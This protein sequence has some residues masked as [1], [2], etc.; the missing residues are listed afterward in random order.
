MKKIIFIVGPTAVG[1]SDVAMELAVKL[2][3]EIVCC[4][5]M[6]IYREINIASNKPSQKDLEKVPHHLVNVISIKR[7]FDVMQYNKM[8][9]K[10]IK[11]IHS[12]EK[13]PLI[14][15]G[16][17]MYV[18]I[19]L[20]GIF[21]GAP[22]NIELRTKLMQIAKK[23]GNDFLHA[24]LS[25]ID[26][27]AAGRIHKND[28]KRVIRAMEVYTMTNE[29]ISKLQEKRDGIW[30]KYD[31]NIFVINRDRD[32]LYGRINRRVE[33]MFKQGLIEEAQKAKK[34]L[35][36]RKYKDGISTAESIIGMKEVFEYLDGK[37]D[38][39]EAKAQIK[40]NTRRL[41]KRQ[42]TWFIKDQRFKWIIVDPN[43]GSKD[44]VKKIISILKEGSSNHGK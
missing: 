26:P 29:Q 27:I 6:Q 4:D 40:Q 10:A 24:K 14:V 28:V 42:I 1:K 38:L 9:L 44:A 18:Q 2:K 7:N 12:R 43:Q 34:I 13:I 36:S 20:D 39:D 22:M 17:G 5:S 23:K 33:A 8:A 31:I 11:D 15:G 30:D 35:K 3:A 25:K 41:A 21:I 19:L 16:S 37:F 32:L